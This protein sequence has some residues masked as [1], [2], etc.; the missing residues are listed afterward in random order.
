V[1]VLSTEEDVR[2]L[3]KSICGKRR[4]RAFTFEYQSRAGRARWAGTTAAERRELAG[5]AA[6]ARWQKAALR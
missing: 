4:A 2:R 1:L 6:A 3:W 5:R